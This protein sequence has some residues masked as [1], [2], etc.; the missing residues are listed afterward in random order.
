MRVTVELFGH[1]RLVSGVR[2]VEARI[3]ARADSS[4]IAAALVSEA[5]ALS[6]VAVSEDG[7]SLMPSYTANL[8]GLAFI[9]DEPV[10]V[11]SGDRIYVFS[12]QAGG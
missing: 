10:S 8:N 2:E 4:H 9:G 3:P 12:S 5:P 6:G 7:R 1:A 11:S